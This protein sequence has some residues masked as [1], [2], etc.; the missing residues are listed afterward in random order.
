M[1]GV[2]DSAIPG[3]GYPRSIR[4]LDTSRPQASSFSFR[5]NILGSLGVSVIS[6]KLSSGTYGYYCIYK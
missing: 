6:E 5:A 4:S 2:Q 3:I 1:H